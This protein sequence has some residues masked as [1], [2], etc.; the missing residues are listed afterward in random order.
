ML[1]TIGIQLQYKPLA[2]D[3]LYSVK[4]ITEFNLICKNPTEHSLQFYQTLTKAGG[5]VVM[6][7]MTIM[8]HRDRQKDIMS[9]E[10]NTRRALKALLDRCCRAASEHEK[11]Q[12]CKSKHEAPVWTSFRSVVCRIFQWTDVNMPKYDNSKFKNT[13]TVYTREKK[14]IHGCHAEVSGSIPSQCPNLSRSQA[15]VQ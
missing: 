8:H 14:L 2:L 7:S 5:D 10:W 9:F 11:L 15:Q 13:T 1:P 4:K 6:I 12:N 3:L